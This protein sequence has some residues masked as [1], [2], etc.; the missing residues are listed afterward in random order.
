MTFDTLLLSRIQFAFTI[1]FHIIFPTLTIGLAA[2]IAL[3][4]GLWLKT[5]EHIYRRECIFW[6]R[7]FALSFG[8]GVVSGVVLSYEVGTNWSGFSEV[9]G[10]IVGPLMMYEVLAAFFLEAGFL[11]VMLFG[12]NRV[13]PR[14]HYLATLMVT[15]GTFFSA[16]WILSANSWMQTPAGFELRDGVFH[17]ANWLDAI[18]TPSFPYR[19]LHMLLAS[20]ITTGFVIAAVSARYLL[21][22]SHPQTGRR[23][24]RVALKS[25]A[26]LVPLQIVVGDLH[27]LVAYEHQPTKVAAIE[28]N[29]ET[30]RGA[31]LL[32][33]AWP[34]AA[35]EKNRY[36]I[37]IP[38]GSSV[39]LEHSLDGEVTGLK[40]VPP[41]DRP[42]VPVVF[43]SFRIMVGCALL[44]LALA[45]V[46][47]WLLARDR[48]EHASRYLRALTFA[49]PLGF[50]ATLAGWFVNEVGR[51]PWIVY[52]HLR[53]ADAVAPV[54]AGQVA[55]SLLMFVIVYL[56]L[57]AA[58]LYFLVKLI[59]R[60]PEETKQESPRLDD[61]APARP[62]FLPA[63]DE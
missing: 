21:D 43:F 27:G 47:A 45:W 33:F 26:V 8:M 18:F 11:G 61:D 46:G 14:L 24:L 1:A 9:A 22:G 10:N 40:E 50:V 16:F 51:Q 20:Y 32:L 4:E 58:F 48:I 25:L 56:L 41:G 15:T 2:F 13:G 49:W 6:G 60:G 5:G 63:S 31:P 36:E 59:R 55:T 17:A 12:W 23:G 35:T 62:A 37:G 28:A 38:R 19:L 7:V 44:M 54:P 29:W 52:G 57:M 39:L 34:D 3:L 53:T 30:T 42:N